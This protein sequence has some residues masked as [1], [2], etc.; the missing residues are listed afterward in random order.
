M[1]E[2]LCH[3]LQRVTG[4][5]YMYDVLTLWDKFRALHAR[6]AGDTTQ[7]GSWHTVCWS[8]VPPLKK[9]DTGILY[10]AMPD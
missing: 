4:V 10:A 5:G 9:S 6:H 7:Y 1:L 8:R 2:P 3:P